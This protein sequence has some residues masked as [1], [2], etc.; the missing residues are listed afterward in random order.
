MCPARGILS[1]VGYDL[2]ILRCRTGGADD[3]GSRASGGRPFCRR[4]LPGS[5]VFCDGSVC[6]RCRRRAD[7]PLS[8]GVAS[9]RA[10][11]ARTA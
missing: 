3:A 2:T 8:Y 1:A 10:G 7:G 11:T 6:A 4:A 5:G 9:A